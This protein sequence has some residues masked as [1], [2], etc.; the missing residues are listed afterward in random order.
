[1]VFFY[2]EELLAPRP[3]P[4]LEVHP[5]SAVRNCL[6]NVFAATPHIRRPFLHLQPEDAPCCGDRD[7]LIMEKFKLLRENGFQNSLKNY[8]PTGSKNMFSNGGVVLK[9]LTMWNNDTEKVHILSYVL[10]F[11]SF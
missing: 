9:R 10:C 5:L 11:G 4:K 3:T 8:T 7:P 1:M 2:G 6:F